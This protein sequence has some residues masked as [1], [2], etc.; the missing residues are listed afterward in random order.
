MKKVSMKMVEGKNLALGKKFKKGVVSEFIIKT[1]AD[2]Q[3][4]SQFEDIAE[5]IAIKILEAGWDSWG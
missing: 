1:G 5:F 3:R 4:R 2:E